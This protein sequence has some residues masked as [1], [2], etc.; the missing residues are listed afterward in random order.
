MDC[1][2]TLGVA[3]CVGLEIA[4]SFLEDIV[5]AAE[6]VYSFSAILVECGCDG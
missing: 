3:R 1:A 5:A 4:G 6:E 2:S